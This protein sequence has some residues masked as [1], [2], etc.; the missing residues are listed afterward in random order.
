MRTTF[1]IAAVGPLLAA[2]ALSATPAA[3]QSITSNLVVNA[4]VLKTCLVLPAV[5]SFGNLAN[6]GDADVDNTTQISVTCTAGTPFAIGLDNGANATGGE[7][8]MSQLLADNSVR[9]LRYQLFRD[10]ARTL[11]WGTSV[12][13]NTV[14][15][16]GALL[17]VLTPV[18]GRVP[19]GESVNAG[20]YTDTVT[21]VV[22]Y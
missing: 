2:A 13:T 19:R 6:A 18:Y 10:A 5:L 11:P 3:A 17:P 15:G 4:T 21:I 7:R 16:T 12:G 14:A 22:T 8:F 20:I 1:K 9:K